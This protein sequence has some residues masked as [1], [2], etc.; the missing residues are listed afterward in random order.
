MKKLL[1]ILFFVLITS[2]AFSQVHGTVKRMDSIQFVN[3]IDLAAGKTDPSY[4]KYGDTI[5][6]EGVVTYNPRW[7]AQSSNRKATWLQMNPYLPFG[8]MN[9]FIEPT[10]VAISPK[11]TLAQLNE[12]VK[13]YEN[14][15]PG[16]TVKCTGILR[17]YDGNTQLN[18]LPIESEITDIPS[19]IDTISPLAPM[20]LKIDSFMANDGSGGQV[21]NFI[22]GEKYEGAL[23]QF[24]NVTVVD[25][26]PNGTTRYNWFVQDSAG[27]KIQIRDNSGY[28]RNDGKQD[29]NLNGYVFTPPTIGTILSFIRGIIV[30]SISA[31]SG[32]TYM[33]SPGYPSDIKI[34]AMAPLISSLKR[35]PVVPTSA[36]SVQIKADITDKDGY[37]KSAKLY[38]S[39]GLNNHVYT[40]LNMVKSVGNNFIGKI[41]P[42]ADKTYIN[43]WV[44]ATDD[45]GLVAIYPDSLATGSLYQ[46]LNNGI[47]SIADI[48]RTPLA[49]GK[50]LWAGD[51]LKNISVPAIVTATLDQLSVVS[52]QDG[53]SPF[54]GIIIKVAAGDGLDAW[55]LGDSVVINSAYVY[56]DFGMTT[57]SAVGKANSQ[58]ISS[59]HNLPKPIMKISPDSVNLKAFNSSEVYEGMLMEFD[60]VYVVYNNAD[61]PLTYGE[62]VVGYDIS[63]KSGLRVDDQSNY[64]DQNFGSDTLKRHQLLKYMRGILFY[65]FGNYKLEPRDKNDIDGY[66][67]IYAGIENPAVDFNI[68][69]YPNPARDQLFISGKLDKSQLVSIRISDWTGREVMASKQIMPGTF[70]RNYDISGLKAG[71][72]LVEIR[73][74]QGSEVR[75]LIKY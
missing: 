4:Y 32:N 75:K 57:L 3:I 36:D 52:V 62:W 48:Q 61:S 15:K 38:Y 21:Q 11:L 8:T 7:Y 60:S 44:K 9:V 35:V 10:E 68:S 58:K 49:S 31:S 55:K 74:S 5:T 47:R 41:P 54:S 43:Y 64:I 30:Q 6:V 65:T 1:N 53:T 20:V 39:A 72:Y 22:T 18:L 67:T 29:N 25:V 42:M 17:N 37:I 73:T 2:A 70:S 66:K 56:E 28:Y 19:V 27:N 24:N 13:F 33:L 34:G 16:Y 50:C 12:A 46:V 69:I 23:V 45:S 51:T 59:G 14:F 71:I 63:R 40:Q 26:A